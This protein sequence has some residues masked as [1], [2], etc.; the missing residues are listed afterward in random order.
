MADTGTCDAELFATRALSLDDADA[1]CDSNCR[2]SPPWL[3][4]AEPVTHQDGSVTQEEVVAY[5]VGD[6]VEIDGNSACVVNAF[7]HTVG[8]VTTA[9]YAL[10]YHDGVTSYEVVRGRVLTMLEHASPW[11]TDDELL[12]HALC[13]EEGFCCN[14]PNVG[15]NQL[16]SCA[17]ACMI[18]A[19][20]TGEDECKATCSEQDV[21]RGCFR[22]VNGHTYSMCQSCADLDDTCPHGVQEHSHACHAGCAVAKE[23]ETCDFEPKDTCGGPGELCFYDPSCSDA[24]SPVYFGGLG[25]NAGGAA[26]NCRY[27][28]FTTA[29]GV[30]YPNCP[31]AESPLCLPTAHYNRTDLYSEEERARTALI[32]R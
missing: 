14:D 17:Q 23:R 8:G 3:L 16:L 15:S 21:S 18:R 13:K 29:G 1:W 11:C 27:C 5:S 2:D 25:C 6:R 4:N 30:S 24:S 28:G 12:C 31:I 32:C 9:F 20:G 19:R 10:D 26:W 22:E 7:H